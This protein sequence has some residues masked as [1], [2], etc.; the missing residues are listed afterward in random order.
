MGIDKARASQVR[1][2]ARKTARAF[3]VRLIGGAARRAL[4]DGS[5]ATVLAVF[6]RSFYVDGGDG[7]L[8]CFGPET[9]G[10]GPLNGLCAL[11]ESIDWQARGLCVGASVAI[12]GG[13]VSIG[14]RLVFSLGAALEW[15]APR[16]I[17]RWSPTRVARGLERLAEAVAPRLPEDG[18]GPLIPDLATRRRPSGAAVAALGGAGAG[19]LDAMVEWLVTAAAGTAPGLPPPHAAGPLI[20]CGPGLTPS[21]DDFVGGAMIAL[22]AAGRTSAAD[23]LGRWALAKARHGTGKISRA[24]LAAAAEGEGADTLHRLVAALFA[25]EAPQSELD[26]IADVGHVSGWDALAGAVAVLA[27]ARPPDSR[28]NY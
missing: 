25:G 7:R 27:N 5:H 6:R 17:R 15:R 8:A 13:A 26:A 1:R 19:G 21:G 11:A 23:S 28:T 9:M 20:G 24:H 4:A 3:R 12:A 2:A 16:P 18:I 14:E 22:N 10:A